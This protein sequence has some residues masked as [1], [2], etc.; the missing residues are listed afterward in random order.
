MTKGE[1]HAH[2]SPAVNEEWEEQ[3]ARGNYFPLAQ[4]GEGGSREGAM[5]GSLGSCYKCTSPLWMA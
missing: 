1:G 3:A 4:S 5:T 2:T